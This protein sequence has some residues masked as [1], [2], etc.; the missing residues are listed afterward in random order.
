M[1][2]R[3]KIPSDDFVLRLF[4]FYTCQPQPKNGEIW[5]TICETYQKPVRDSLK[6]EAAPVHASLADIYT[7]SAMAGLDIG[8]G[9]TPKTWL[10]YA[11]ALANYLCVLHVFN[12][13]QPTGQDIDPVGLVRS[14]EESLKYELD[15]PGAIGMRGAIIA[16]RFIPCKLLNVALVNAMFPL[17]GNVLEIGPG[18]G[19]LG[20][21][22]HTLRLGVYHTMDLPVSSVIHAY[23]LKTAFPDAQIWM[24][25]ESDKE[26]LRADILIHGLNFWTEDQMDFVVNQDSLPEMPE[27]VARDY[28]DLIDSILAPHG[29]F[30]SINQESRRG[31]QS[32]VYELV[33][34]TKLKRK[35]RMPF[36][37][38]KGYV[39]ECYDHET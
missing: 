15:Y 26:Y 17:F 3:G 9:G 14:L 27:R 4:R 39:V 1:R 23:A 18:I 33:K 34:G 21:L 6:G 20:Y 22:I 25:G 8:L 7:N 35:L 2:A 38:R 36:W 24:N 28:I 30:I 12:P 31:G 29:Q 10:D 5:E 11:V 32:V 19:M 13:E 37:G 16:D